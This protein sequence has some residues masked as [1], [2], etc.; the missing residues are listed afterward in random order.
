MYWE[1]KVDG[2]TFGCNGASN[3]VNL[4]TLKRLRVED[5]SL[6]GWLTKLGGDPR[7]FVMY[8]KKGRTI[9]VWGA[10]LIKT[11]PLIDGY[12]GEVT[13]QCSGWKISLD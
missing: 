5:T 7:D 8:D 13:F 10:F 3:S 6:H 1:I 4:V 9:N 11:E 12:L 2:K